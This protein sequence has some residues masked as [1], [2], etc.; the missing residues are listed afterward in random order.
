MK[1]VLDIQIHT[2]LS[3]TCSLLSFLFQQTLRNK[4]TNDKTSI[5]V[6]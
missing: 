4:E 5:I 6:W 2:M 1:N 3:N